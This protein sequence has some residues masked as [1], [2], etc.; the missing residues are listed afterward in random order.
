MGDISLGIA[1]S[2]GSRQWDRRELPVLL[3][4]IRAPGE[5]HRPMIFGSGRDL[6]R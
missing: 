4:L 2:L 6:Y 1:D 3:L 5:T